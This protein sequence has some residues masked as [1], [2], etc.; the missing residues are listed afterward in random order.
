MPIYPNGSQGLQGNQGQQGN[1]GINGFQGPIGK[2]G[3][4]SEGAQGAPGGLQGAKGSLGSLGDTGNI[5][6][7][8]SQGQ[9]G[10]L[11]DRGFQ[12]DSGH[13][14]SQGLQGLKNAIVPTQG[15][16]GVEYVELLCVEMPEIKFEDILYF[17]GGNQGEK[18]HK[19][20]KTI[21]NYFIQVCE[22]D[23]IKPI[24]AVATDF[25]KIGCYVKED[26]LIVNIYDEDL[27][28]KL[29]EINVKLSGVR[30]GYWNRRFA[31]YSKEDLL[32]NTKFWDS[33]K[34]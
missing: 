7:Q 28:D 2:G 22:Q 4:G 17:Q 9:P 5:G 21:D 12:G 20:E 11:G 8:G 30:K 6:L 10:N 19:I 25:V 15:S 31:E 33:W 32:K 23:S 16:Q 3:T 29:I 14:G 1:Q 26:K 27:A 24:S 34:I 13:I 18:F